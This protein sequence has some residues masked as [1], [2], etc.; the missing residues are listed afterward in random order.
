MKRIVILGATGSIGQQT[1]EVVRQRRDN[2]LLDVA[3]NGSS[4]FWLTDIPFQDINGAQQPFR[5]DTIS[6]EMTVCGN[7]ACPQLLLD[8]SRGFY[9]YSTGEPSKYTRTVYVK[10]RNTPGRDEV[11]VQAVVTWQSGAYGGL[12]SVTVEDELYAW[13]PTE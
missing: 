2:T 11:S 4:V 5:I 8:A 7:G 1:I 13:V 9:N 6:G 12:R 10:M 3:K